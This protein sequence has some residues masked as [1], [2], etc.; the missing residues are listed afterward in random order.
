MCIKA[1]KDELESVKNLM[2][3]A[4]KAVV[5]EALHAELENVVE[6]ARLVEDLRMGSNEAQALQDLIADTFDGIHVNLAETPTYAAL[7]ERV[8]LSEFQNLGD[9]AACGLAA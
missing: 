6:E 9:E 5:A 3:M 1:G 8:V 7:V 4:L 2:G